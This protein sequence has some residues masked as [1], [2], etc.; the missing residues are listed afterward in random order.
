VSDRGR[1]EKTVAI[2]TAITITI[3]ITTTTQV[4]PR[5]YPL[6]PKVLRPGPPFAAAVGVVRGPHTVRI[7]DETRDHRQIAVWRVAAAADNRLHPRD[8]RGVEATREHGRRS[9][10]LAAAPAPPEEVTACRAL[11]RRVGV[12][13]PRGAE[14]G[15]WPVRRAA[16]TFLVCVAVVATAARPF[17]AMAARARLRVRARA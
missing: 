5:Q 15:P 8:V 1:N 4:R 13:L 11:K 6:L 10:L 3:T 16:I 9:L 17:R 7:A 2:T 12:A 14:R